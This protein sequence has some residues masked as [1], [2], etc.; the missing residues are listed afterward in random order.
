MNQSALVSSSIFRTRAKFN[1]AC[2]LHFF[3][4]SVFPEAGESK[5][6]F[7]YCPDRQFCPVV[8][9]TIT[10][11]NITVPPPLSRFVK[12]GTIAPGWG[13][14]RSRVQFKAGASNDIWL[15]ISNLNKNP[16]YLA[17]PF[18]PNPLPPRP[19]TTGLTSADDARVP[20]SPPSPVPLFPFPRSLR[21][22]FVDV[23]ST[24]HL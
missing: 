15:S 2:I 19:P 13:H 8:R 20:H 7:A 21:Q 17:Y 14:A 3:P 22:S 12:K 23:S 18:N 9:I 24:S 10:Y 4:F 1:R 16:R 6:A 5:F 11:A